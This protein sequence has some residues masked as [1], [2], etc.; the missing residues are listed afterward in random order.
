[1]P[2]S[3]AGAVWRATE[4]ARPWVT[5]GER[6]TL[7]M[8]FWRARLRPDIFLQIISFRL[9]GMSLRPVV[10]LLVLSV[11]HK[12][13]HDARAVWRSKPSHSL[14]TGMSEM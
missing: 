1:M 5:R 7:A 6:G 8:S 13:P 12:G 2:W 4:G 9:T 14:P 3:R 11:L 10:L